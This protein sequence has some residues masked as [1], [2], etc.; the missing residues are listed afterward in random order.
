MKVIEFNN[1]HIYV[2]ILSLK[3]LL[4]DKTCFYFNKLKPWN[5]KIK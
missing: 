1:L 5:F 3:K 2:K 4:Y